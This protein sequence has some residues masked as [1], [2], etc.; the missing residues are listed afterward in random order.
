ML[1]GPAATAS[2]WGKRILL[3]GASSG[4]GEAAAE[5]F[6]RRGAAV[7]VAARRRNC[8]TRSSIGSPRRAARASARLRPVRP[9]RRRRPRRQGRERPRRHRHPDQQRRPVHPPAAG[10]IAGT[11]ARRRTHDG[12][13]L[14]L[15]A[16]TDP[17][18]RPG[19]RERRDG[20]IINVSTW[21]VLERIL[22]AV[23][24]LQRVEGGAHRG[25]P[26]HRNGVGRPRRAFDDPVLP[27]GEDTDDRA[28]PGVRRPA[29]AGRRR[30]GRLDD[31][32]GAHRPV[33]IAPRMAL[34]AHALNSV[35]PGAV[36]A[37]HEAAAR[38]AERLTTETP[39]PKRS[40]RQPYRAGVGRRIG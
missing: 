38:P 3:T 26:G 6:A 23:R 22:P 29:R 18:P 40:L 11:L 32:R 14:L 8:S 31:H 27:A 4:I 1:S 17:R 5:K 21:G 37:G 7:V 36:D 34:T 12:P 24:G 33:R 25:Q 15:P 13:Q 39:V 10:R 2:T 16:A 28:D 20:H 9:R 35:A 30:G 19:M